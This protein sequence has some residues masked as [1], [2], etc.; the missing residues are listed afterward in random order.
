MNLAEVK[1]ANERIAKLEDENAALS[2]Q[3]SELNIALLRLEAQVEQLEEA[4]IV[5]S[6]DSSPGL[7][8][9]LVPKWKSKAAARLAEKEHH[10][11]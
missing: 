11:N 2:S 6:L 7:I 3:L 4:L 10:G 5:A 1:R 9:D 8:Q